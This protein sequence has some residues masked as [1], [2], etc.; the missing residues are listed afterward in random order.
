[1]HYQPVVRLADREILGVEALVRWNH[2][3]RGTIPPI[4]FIPVAEE[5]G[6]IIPD[7]AMDSGNGLPRRSSSP[8][9]AHRDEPEDRRDRRGCRGALEQPR[10][11]DD[12]EVRGR[13][14]DDRRDDPE[15]RTD[16][17]HPAMADPVGEHAEWGGQHELR[18]I[19]QGEP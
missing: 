16:L 11:T 4:Q 2:P 10:P 6:L 9:V 7:G 17:H 5:T 14:G 15:Q 3:T 12:G 8:A 18:R 13:P 1:L 19:E